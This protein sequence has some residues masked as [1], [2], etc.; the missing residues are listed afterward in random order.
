[1]NR[2]RGSQQR[3]LRMLKLYQAHTS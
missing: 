1:M 3:I 2:T